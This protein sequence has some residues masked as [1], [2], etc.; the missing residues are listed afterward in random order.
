MTTGI[1]KL[2]IQTCTALD[3]PEI[4]PDSKSVI[5]KDS[6]D[7]AALNG[8]AGVPYY[9]LLDSLLELLCTFYERDPNLRKELFLAI[10]NRLY[11]L[12]FLD[13]MPDIW[14]L[15]SI[16]SKFRSAFNFLVTD[17]KRNL[18]RVPGISLTPTLGPA[19]DFALH[20]PDEPNCSRGRYEYD[21][22]EIAEI[23]QG[24]F[25]TVCKA[26]KR[27]DGC[28]YAVKKIPFKYRNQQE[29]KQMLREVELLAKLHHPNVVAYKTAWIEN[30]PIVT[31]CEEPTTVDS[32]QSTVI[33]PSSSSCNGANSFGHTVFVD[34]SE[35]IV[36]LNHLVQRC[37]SMIEEQGCDSLDVDQEEE[38][39]CISLQESSTR[40]LEFVVVGECRQ[41]RQNSR[42]DGDF[43][44]IQEPLP[45]RRQRRKSSKRSVSMDM[46]AAREHAFQLLKAS[47]I[48]GILFIQMELCSGN[49]AEW[50]ER[51]NYRLMVD[52][53]SGNS[54]VDMQEAL[55]IF[56][57]ILKAVQYVHSQ[58]LIHRDLKPQN[59]LFDEKGSSVKLGDFGLATVNS[60]G[61]QQDLIHRPWSQ[62]TEH[63]QGVGTSL[64]SA[65]EQRK[66]VLYDNKVDIYSLGVVLTELTCPFS[67]AHERIGE[68]LKLREGCLPVSLKNLPDVASTVRAMCHQDPKD[69]PS[70]TEVLHSSLFISKDEII[71]NL[72]A[73][74]KKTASESASLKAEVKRLTAEISSYKEVYGPLNFNH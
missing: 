21:F 2:S 41:V 43:E 63:T 5:V 3:L 53:E 8:N 20:S 69:R 35:E 16:R 26:K 28:L 33:M 56:R 64:Y 52:K 70:A 25:G 66:Q 50:L 72:K 6:V 29:L 37:S 10:R 46:V 38:G 24:G 54:T 45:E 60:Q 65:P 42:S 23:A 44:V 13:R 27:V 18:P 68:L 34:N 47:D 39:R 61:V 19:Q 4:G 51:R 17:A 74:L 48:G 7:P 58:E 32:L 36:V 73:E 1:P 57:Q 11:Q 62:K 12:Q 49:L 59:I 31:V 67:T 40:E 22:E 9:L 15:R 71:R 30:M 55:T 14:E